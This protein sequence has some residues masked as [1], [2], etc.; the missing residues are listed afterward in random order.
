[1]NNN[2]GRTTYALLTAV[3]VTGIF[4]PNAYYLQVL[5]L[6]GIYCIA[7]VGLNVLLGAAGQIS[8]GHG[9]F[10]AVGAYTSAAALSHS[11][12]FFLSA[13]AGMLAAT[14]FGYVIGFGALRLHGNYL[15]LATL[16]FGGLVVGLLGELPW[17]G[18]SLGV[19]GISGIQL[20]PV[21]VEGPWPEFLT[22]WFV[23]ALAA[24]TCQRLFRSAPGL[25]LL[26]IRE[27]DVA[28]S[29]LGFDIAKYKTK[30]F[31]FSALLAGLAG[32]FYASYV[33]ALVP[34]RFGVQESIL[35][36]VIVTVGGFGSIG[37]TILASVV[38]IAAPE[39][40]RE[41]EDYRL[42]IYGVALTFLIVAFPGGLGRL[43][44]VAESSVASIVR[45]PRAPAGATKAGK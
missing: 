31:V 29:M 12:P 28:A 19:V 34:S 2:Q 11:I 43:L 37:G 24:V 5:S 8:L 40:A 23:A 36:V 10:M 45:R 7:A 35:L 20:G 21:A 30:A 33:G 39:L 38:L 32:A 25:V 18:G 17:F 44:T 16:A 27:D 26:A 4:A 3:L 13:M 9:A 41:W 42:L 14:V 6:A 1:M 15:A 22:I